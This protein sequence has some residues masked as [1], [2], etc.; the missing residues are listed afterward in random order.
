M[1][2]QTIPSFLHSLIL[3]FLNSFILSSFHL[4]GCLFALCSLIVRSWFAQGSEERAFILCSK[5]IYTIV[6]IVI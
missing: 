1:K 6:Q 2:N 3:S 5:S 4:R